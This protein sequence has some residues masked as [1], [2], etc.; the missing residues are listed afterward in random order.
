MCLNQILRKLYPND[1]IVEK[2]IQMI[3]TEIH[4]CAEDKDPN[5]DVAEKDNTA[6]KRVDVSDLKRSPDISRA[7]EN[8]VIKN[9]HKIPKTAIEFERS[10][11]DLFREPELLKN[12]ILNIKTSFYP[13]I[14]KE[15]LSAR[16]MKLV[17]Y[18]LKENM[19][20]FRS[21]VNGVV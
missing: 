17:G 15:D 16:I 18:F 14:F 19:T 12:Y 2:S 1:H 5:E 4:Q 10:C 13:V 11:L 20:L 6:N 9:V 8:K 21:E 3:E 7:L